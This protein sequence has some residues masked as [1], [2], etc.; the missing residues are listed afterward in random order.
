MNGGETE[1]TPQQQDPD[2]TSAPWTVY[3]VR[4]SDSTLYTGITNN[5]KKRLAEHNS[6]SGARYTR[7]RRPVCLVYREGLPNRAAASRR[8]HQL[9]KLSRAEKIQIITPE[10][11]KNDRAPGS[12]LH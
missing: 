12:P 4:C 5:L 6:G 7:S 10:T 8:E 3:I 11:A 1:P 9:K 2:G